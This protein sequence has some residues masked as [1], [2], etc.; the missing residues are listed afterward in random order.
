MIDI[1]ALLKKLY[2]DGSLHRILRNPLAQFGFGTRNYIGASLLPEK[3]VVENKYRE[4]QIRFR[5]PI[6]NAGTRYSPVQYKGNQGVA[7]FDVE[8]SYSDIGSQL[9]GREYDT[10]L[11]VLRRFNPTQGEMSLEA[12]TQ[13]LNWIDLTINRPLVEYNEK[14]RWDA[15]VDSSVVLTGANGFTETVAYSNPSGHRFNA[16]G[17]WSSDAY[18]P[19]DDI[20]TAADLL[21][22][23]GFTPSRILTGQSVMAIIQK[24]ALMRD[25]AGTLSLMSGTVTGQPGRVSSGRL[26]NMMAENNLPPIES[27]NLQYQTTDSTGYFLSRSVM[28]MVATTGRDETIDRGDSEPI[29]LADTLGYTAIGTPSGGVEPGRR[30]YTEAFQNKPPRIDAQGWQCSLP[31]ITEPEAIVV[32]K[33]I[34]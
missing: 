1:T 23:K 6:A 30:S 27:F 20:M 18:D 17:T 16:A 31:V 7:S 21:I 9:T 4:E 33:S 28:V 8:L 14:M 22:S 11:A 10:L 12:M 5:S 34:S 32:I 2:D 26:D 15:I 29:M 24:N 25:R 19:M 13:I 3:T